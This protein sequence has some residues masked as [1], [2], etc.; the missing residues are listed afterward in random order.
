MTAQK[1]KIKV[2][3]KFVDKH[4]DRIYRVGEVLS[5]TKRRYDEIISKD[6]RLVSLV[7]E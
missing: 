5:V 3:R 6:E 2:E 4:T 1:I 7:T